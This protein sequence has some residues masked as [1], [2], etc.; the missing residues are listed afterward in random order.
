MAGKLIQVDSET[1]TTATSTVTLTGIT[2]NSV[3]LV[4]GRN[5]KGDTDN[6]AFRFRCSDDGTPITSDY[7]VAYYRI[8]TSSPANI[9]ATSQAHISIGGVGTGSSGNEQSNFHMMLYNMFNSSEYSTGTFVPVTY[10]ATPVLEGNTGSFG[11]R[12][13]QRTNEAHFLLQSGNFTSGQ[14]AMYKVL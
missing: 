10:N 12:N 11:L 14:F 9:G 2:D 3:Y 6:K 1:I 13:A 5:I 7:D 4:V 8:R